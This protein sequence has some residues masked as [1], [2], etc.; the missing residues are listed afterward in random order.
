MF[1][2]LPLILSAAAYA[3]D[4]PK[5]INKLTTEQTVTL[6]N[7]DLKETLV[8]SQY[9]ALIKDKTQYKAD[10]CTFFKVGPDCIIANDGSVIAKPEPAKPAEVKK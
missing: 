7:F 4:A 8:R 6:E 3:A 5:V 9:A 1:K 10:I 2:L